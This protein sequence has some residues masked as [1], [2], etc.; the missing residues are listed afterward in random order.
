MRPAL[1]MTS[2]VNRKPSAIDAL[3]TLTHRKTEID[4]V[5]VLQSPC[6][7]QYLTR[8]SL[9]GKCRE[10]SECV[11]DSTQCPCLQSHAEGSVEN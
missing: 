10:K 6:V 8:V 3:R 11:K 4:E 1:T 5:A 7:E 9:N 2:N